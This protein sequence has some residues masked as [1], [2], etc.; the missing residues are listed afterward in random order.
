MPGDYEVGKGKPPKH[1]QFKPGQSGNLKGRP[2]GTKNFATDLMEELSE[3]INIK[4][5]GKKIAVTKQR[6][7]LKS[8][9]AKAISGDPKAVQVV[10]A[11]LAE[12]L[13]M[14][15]DSDASSISPADAEILADYLA[16]RQAGDR[17]P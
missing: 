7:L 6:A 1:S 3:Q 14:R 17:T 11:M 15:S 9:V 5:G 8:I 4:E 2:R 13:G 10:M 16:R 12:T